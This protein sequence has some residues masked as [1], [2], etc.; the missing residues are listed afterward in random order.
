MNSVYLQLNNSAT[1]ILDH[2]PGF[3]D[4]RARRKAFLAKKGQG[5]THTGEKTVM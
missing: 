2:R 3:L 1:N 4:I 5:S